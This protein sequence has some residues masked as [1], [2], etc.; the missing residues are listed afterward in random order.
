MTLHDLSIRRAVTFSMIFIAVAVFGIVSLLRLSPELL[1]NITFPVAS[2]ITSYSG[3]GPEDLEKLIA[4]PIEE[5]ATVIS[6]VTEVTSTCKEGLVISIVSFDWGTNMDVAV[7]NIR[8]GLD[9]IRDYL[10]KDANEPIIFK[11]DVSMQPILYM[12]VSSD[13]LTPAEVRRLSENEVEPVLERIEGVAFAGTMGGEKREIQVQIDRNKI[14]AYGLSIHQIVNALRGENITMQAGKIQDDKNSELLRTVGEFTSVDQI[15]KVLVSYQGRA[16]IY[17]R[18]VAQVYDT[19][20]EKKQM[21]NINGKPGVSLYIQKQSGTN[22]VQVAD[23]VMKAVDKLNTSLEGRAKITVIMDLSRF[24]KRSLSNLSTV[25]I[26]G[27]ILAILV[28]FFFLHNIRSVIIIALAIPMSVIATFS[29]MDFGGVTLNMLSMGGLALG[30]GM[31]VDNAIVV[32]ENVF[33]HRTEEGEDRRTAASKGTKE[34]ATAIIA[35]TLT[36]I[37]VFLPVVFVPGI[38][39]ILFKDQA[40]TVVFSLACSLLVALTLIPLLCSRFLRV[41]TERKKKT[42]TYT[43]SSKF[44][45]YMERLDEFY[46]GILNWALNHRKLVVISMG[47]IFLISVSIVWPLRLVGTEFIPDIDQG[48]LIISVETPPGTSLKAT[49]E[50]VLQVERIIMEEAKAELDAIYSTAGSGEGIAALFGGGGDNS[51]SITLELIPKSQRD[52]SYKD[53]EQ[54]IKKRLANTSGMRLLASADPGAAMLGFGG[55]PVVVEI[56]GYDQRIAKELAYQVKDIVEGIKGTTGVETSIESANPETQIIIDRDR[57]YSMGLN[58]GTIASTVNASVYGTVATLYREGGDEYNV[59]VRLQ[60]KD[61]R[62]KDDIYDTVITSPLMKQVS[63]KN[64]A[65]LKLTEGPVNVRRKNQERLVTVTANLYGRDLGSVNRELQAKLK[66]IKVPEGFIISTG[67]SAEEQMESFKWLGLALLGAMFLVYAVMA[68]LY[69]SLLEPF[70]IMFTFP[71]AIIGVV[72]IFFFTGTIFSIIAFVGLIMLAG[73]VVNNGIVMVDYINRLRE[74]HGM[75]LREAV[76]LGGRRRLRPIL[77]TSLTTIFG[78]VPLALGF[79]AGAELRAPMARAVVG[80]LSTSMVLT[81]VLIP[82]IY[83]IFADL[84]ERRKQSKERKAI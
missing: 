64:V 49:E 54:A 47:I 81:L 32:L 79:G 67:G 74:E 46:Q 9:M 1:P 76:I 66:S 40:L 3:V 5:A 19:Y 70:I 34:V 83:T 24:I 53:I 14:E 62:T 59:L 84:R 29:A 25:A 16:P 28:L 73:I 44:G 41:E 31:L 23:K 61:R 56:F 57:A 30:I 58:V 51:A 12:G 50:V 39:G 68:S 45:Y 13:T 80:G 11:F 36:T 7:A 4:R 75:S 77:M 35:S 71:L 8:E 26:Q 65:S 10:P 63:L 55:A 6:N 48:E 82:V 43:L 18:D 20:A 42:W 17:V 69:E 27:G 33:R 22:T 15:E 72:W 2:I 52:R 60:E 78:M 21:V 38:A 37:A